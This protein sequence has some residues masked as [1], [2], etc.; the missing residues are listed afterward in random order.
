MPS[1]TGTGVRHH[2][3]QAYRR[4]VTPGSPR[5]R[6][7]DQ[8]LI[9][10]R[11][12]EHKLCQILINLLVNGVKFTQTGGVTLIVKL[13]RLNQEK[14][15]LQFLVKDTGIGLSKP[16]ADRLF[17]PFVQAMTDNSEYEGTG[18]GLAIS[19]QFVELMGGEIG[20]ESEMG[21]GS[22]FHFSIQVKIA[23]GDELE[24]GPISRRVIGTEP[25][26]STF[27]L[28]I[29]E[30][31]VENRLL[32]RRMLESVGFEVRE[33]ENGQA[34]IEMFKQWSPHL[35]WMDMRMPVMDGYE[36]THRIKAADR[37][38]T[39]V[40]VALTASTFEEQRS[41]I[42]KA[43]CDDFVRKPFQEHEIFDVVARHLGLRFIYEK[44][45]PEQ[46]VDVKPGLRAEDLSVLPT[47]D[48]ANLHFAAAS[49]DTECMAELIHRIEAISCAWRIDS[50]AAM[51]S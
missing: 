3:T 27:R 21:K 8:V 12:D 28:L 33:A 47:K 2:R 24:Q 39:T 46:E 18:L 43:G 23:C 15:T 34:G 51:G 38:Q 5:S 20:V 50:Q 11:T 44:T 22:T 41:Q 36:A 32:L 31:K 16:D 19:K 6:I 17:R 45:E 7:E 9:Y 30:D 48:L 26:Q 4:G 49:A 35:I 42:L 25:G 1:K 29:V 13:L 40:I 37:G 10:I 14:L